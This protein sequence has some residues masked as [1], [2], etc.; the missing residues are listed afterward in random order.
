VG[1]HSLRDAVLRLAG[2][3]ALGALVACGGGGGDSAAT[4]TT[5][6]VRTTA[7][8]APV[9]VGDC[10]N[11]PRLRIGGALD[12]ASIEPVPCTE[13]HEVEVA[14]VFD[15]PAGP[16]VDFPGAVSVDGYAADECIE[17]FE[18]YVGAPYESSALDVLIVAPD[19][20]G[21]GA[22]DRRIACVLYHV[23]FQPLTQPVAGSG[24]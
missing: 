7:E 18:G 17:R 16:E 14:A 4:T 8:E 1:T 12:P 20:D 15:Y 5:T 24:L 3:A 13:A 10:G 9:A 21:W 6:I 19:E 23:D 2:L 11:V 22:G